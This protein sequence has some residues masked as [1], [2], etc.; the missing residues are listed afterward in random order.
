MNSSRFLTRLPYAVLAALAVLQPTSPLR[1]ATLQGRVS[2]SNL[3]GALQGVVVTVEGTTLTATTDRSGHYTVTKV[4]TGEVTVG[5]DYV[6]SPAVT[7]TVTVPAA[8]AVVMLDVAVATQTVIL[9]DYVV[10]AYATGTARAT[11]IQ[12][13]SDNFREVV[14]SDAFGQF[15]DGNAAEA[16]NRIPGLSIERDQGEG[17]F[18]VVRGIDPNLNV[19]AI[20]GIVLAAP[21]ADERK[22]LLDTIP[23]EVIDN[24]QVSK[25]TTPDQPGDAIGGYI[26]LNSPS[27]FDHEGRTARVSTALFYSELTEDTGGELS[28]SVGDRFGADKAWGIV[29]SGVYS[30]RDFGSDNVEADNWDEEEDSLGNDVFIT[31]E[32]QYRDYLLTRERIGVNAN[33]E[34]RPDDAN[35]YFVRAG[36]NQYRDNEERQALVLN[37]EDDI[38]NASFTGAGPSSIDAT[39]IAVARELKLREETMRIFVLSAGGEH[40]P[41]DWVVDYTAALSTADEDTPDEFEAVYELDGSSEG[42]FTGLTGRNPRVDFTG[43]DDARDPSLYEFDGITKTDQLAEERDL[44]G[45]LNFRRDLSS[46]VFSY[47]KFGGIVRFKTKDNDIEAFESDDNPG[48]VDNY[49]GFVTNGLRDFLGTGVPGI[50][51]SI[52]SFFDKNRADFDME[53]A[54]EDSTVGDYS[55]NEDVYAGYLMTGLQVDKTRAI[56]GA[57]VEH[58]EFTT[59]GFS[60]DDDTETVGSVSAS[61]DYTNVLPGL[62]LRHDATKTLVFRASATQ[63]ISRPS[64]FQSAPGRLIVPGDGEVEQGNP[65]LDPYRSTNLDFSV[66]HFNPTLGNFTVGVFH[67]D[68]RDFIYAQ[69]IPG[70]DIATG[71]DLITYRNGDAG[72]ILGLELG[73]QR[74]LFAGFGLSA[75]GTWTDGEATVL[76]EEAGDPSRDLPFVK[77]SDFLAQVALTFE[78]KRFFARLGY[79]FRSDYLDEIGGEALE[80]RY[81]DAYYQLDFYSSFAFSKNW[82]AYL[83]VNNLTNQPLEAYWGESGRLAQYEEYG[84]SGAVGLKWQY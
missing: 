32:F 54:V 39:D 45:K 10:S 33:L 49:A 4:P 57:R 60:Y 69:N 70:G 29:V 17:R 42:T 83:E 44:S 84:V 73:W 21:S 47:V 72:S 7:R 77:Q 5:F 13:S 27:A 66:Q 46:D 41:G 56:I 37:L 53:R 11:N 15:P 40:R 16:L 38:D 75:S 35:R 12:R 71:F 79:T 36:F 8:D 63:S 19:V 64:F 50:N 26:E 1:A 25:T 81:I 6:G 67:K 9:D 3:T 65:D 59:D 58:T 34:F 51:P 30:I 68:I 14:A 52:G 18:V 62:H 20:D 78:Q 76:G 55:S 2:D 28:F 43:G 48:A 82:K 24:L 31:E 61:K 23:L 80:D 22:T 74:A